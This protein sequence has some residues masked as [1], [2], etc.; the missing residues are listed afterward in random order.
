MDSE[1]TKALRFLVGHLCRQVEFSALRN[2]AYE[3]LAP[4]LAQKASSLLTTPDFVALIQKSSETQH[5]LIEAVA[6]ED[7][8][9][10]LQ[11]LAAL[12]EMLTPP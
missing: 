5:Q 11:A 8:S 6:S 7:W 12:I 10:T 2:R 9:A 3:R 1:A 4:E